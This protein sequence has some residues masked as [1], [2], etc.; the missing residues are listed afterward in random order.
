MSINSKLHPLACATPGKGVLR[1]RGWDYDCGSLEFAIQRSQ[2]DMYL[3]QDRQWNKTPCWFAQDFVEEDDGQSISCT[4]GSALVD[5]LLECSAS[6]VFNFRLRST[7][8]GV[9]EENP[10]KL[11]AG[12]MSSLAGGPGAAAADS[13]AILAVDRQAQAPA[14]PQPPAEQAAPAEPTEPPAPAPA[15]SPVAT[16]NSG[17]SPLPWIILVLVL[18]LLAA[19]TAW[20][21]L[22]NRP[23][24]AV[25]DASDY[26]TT[27]ESVPATDQPCSTENMANS[28]EL[29]FVQACM[30]QIP[31]SN[32]LLQII[33]AAK[34]AGHCGIAQRLYAHRSQAGDLQIARRYAQEYDPR[35]HQPNSC[36][37]E[38][39]AT[40]A[41]YWYETILGYAPDDLE[42]RQ[43]LEDLQ[44]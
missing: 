12:L 13:S 14:V 32:E 28:T 15:V 7:A 29:A 10:M 22:F 23:A 1:I 39:D 16:G 17:K 44:P 37:A 42:A 43:R 25:L 41:A 3:Q 31:D 38:A 27:A 2:D 34:A 8:E 35:Y 11:E 26:Q 4:V 20:F 40:T 21:W 6:S 30:Q 19:A 5:P 33:E 24:A 36:F 9:E 18:L